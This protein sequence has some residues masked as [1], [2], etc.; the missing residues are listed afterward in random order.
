MTALHAVAPRRRGH[1]HDR[2]VHLRRIRYASDS[3]RRCMDE[4]VD[5]TRRL[6]A[7]RAG[8]DGALDALMPLVYDELKRIARSQL[9][10]ERPEHT[11]QPTALVHEAYLRLL[12][13]HSVDWQD[14]AYF[15]GLAATMMRRI[16]VNHARD[17]AADKRGG[18]LAPVTLQA[19]TAAGQDEFDVLALHLALEQLA[20]RDP[21]KAR[22]VELKYFGGLDYDE[23]ASA[24]G[25]S[26]ATVRRDFSVARLWLAHAMSA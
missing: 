19:G 12:G 11:L 4:T 6:Q 22:I 3:R 21:R 7:A 14:R 16:L 1:R 24:V 10:R 15:L 8:D 17:R 18:G 20:Q 5:I 23:I 25:V 13:A 9:A 2:R 26:S